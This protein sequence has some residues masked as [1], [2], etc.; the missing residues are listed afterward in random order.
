MAIPWTAK[1]Q[2]LYLGIF[3]IIVF[4]IAFF[5]WANATKPTCF[6][7]KQNQKE[8]GIDCGGPCEKKC[9]GEI[10]NLIVLWS[11]FFDISENKYDAVALVKNP[12][13]FLALPS[14]KYQFKF[15]DKNNILIAIKEGE[16]FITPAETFPIFET[17]I[18]TSSRIPSR[19]FIEFEENLK[20]E[21]RE[22]EKL[23][24][25]VSQKEFFNEPPF[26]RL[27][28]NL[29]NKSIA[30]VEDIFLAAVLYDED[31]NAQGASVTKV[32][33]ISSQSSQKVVFTWPELF[34]EKPASIEV[35]F[36]VGL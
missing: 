8:E 14:L 7:N 24:L 27:V 17:N 32:D 31:K 6:D 4:I 9:L 29:E 10:R 19:V 15:Y 21:R 16:T 36:R 20:W 5:I 25:V 33:S 1:R 28:I 30:P 35:F 2:L 22:K 12:N 26:P 23:S 18:D 3:L 11:K 34:S 13:A